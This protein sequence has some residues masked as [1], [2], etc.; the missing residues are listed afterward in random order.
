MGV[1]LALVDRLRRALAP[2]SDSSS[3]GQPSETRQDVQRGRARNGAGALTPEQGVVHGPPALVSGLP[4]LRRSRQCFLAAMRNKMHHSQMDTRLQQ[5]SMS[6]LERLDRL[7]LEPVEVGERTGGLSALT[8]IVSGML[9]AR[10][11]E[12][13]Q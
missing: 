4:R 8:V 7:D 3:T 1:L 10:I 9:A 11:D 13:W 6:P 12:E 2:L 5:P